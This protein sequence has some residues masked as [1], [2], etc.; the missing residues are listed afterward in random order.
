MEFKDPAKRAASLAAEAAS[1]AAAGPR[2]QDGEQGDGS[3]KDGN[4]VV[5]APT[6][7]EVMKELEEAIERE[8]ADV[9]LIDNVFDVGGGEP[10]FAHFT[11]E[12]WALL[13]LRFELHLLVHAFRHDCRNPERRGIQPSELGAYYYRYFTKGLNVRN[14]GVESIEQLIGLIPDSAVICEDIVESQLVDDL[15]TNEVFVKLTEESRRERQRR[16]DEGD[17]SAVLRFSVL[18]QDYGPVAWTGCG[19]CVA[20]RTGLRPSHGMPIVGRDPYA[21]QR[22]SWSTPM[23]A[24]VPMVGTAPVM[25]PPPGGLSYTPRRAPAPQAQYISRVDHPAFAPGKGGVPLPAHAPPSAAPCPGWGPQ[26]PVMM[27]PPRG[28]PYPQAWRPNQ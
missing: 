9:F 15:E 2:K 7:D 13:S 23:A 3:Q 6:D 18:P 1:E 22:P 25:A 16:L 4:D 27:M 21:I 17:Q 10:L 19:G 11:V 12:D 24:T 8:E 5:R 14:Y 20:A 26:R 28:A